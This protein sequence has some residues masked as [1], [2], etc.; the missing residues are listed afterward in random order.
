MLD[1]NKLRNAY[2]VIH[3][4]SQKQT[5]FCRGGAFTGGCTER[6]GT[7]GAYRC[8]RSYCCLRQDYES[9]VAEHEL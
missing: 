2:N 7:G 4:M 5:S 8:R 6:A 9:G 1:I 3:R